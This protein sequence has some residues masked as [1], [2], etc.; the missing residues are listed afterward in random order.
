MGTKITCDVEGCDNE[1][2]VIHTS[3]LPDG[4]CQITMKNLPDD[5]GKKRKKYHPLNNDDM[6]QKFTG[7]FSLLRVMCPKHILPRFKKD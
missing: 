1:S 3:H 5:L 2:L 4:W 7:S 6:L